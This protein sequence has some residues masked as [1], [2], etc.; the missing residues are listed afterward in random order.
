[1]KKPS[2]LVLLATS[3]VLGIWQNVPIQAQE[4]YLKN[5]H[6]EVLTENGAADWKLLGGKGTTIVDNQ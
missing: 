4:N 1:M 2:L 6:F 3:L 5:G